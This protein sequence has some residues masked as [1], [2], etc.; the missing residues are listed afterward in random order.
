MI[1]KIIEQLAT[2]PVPLRYCY[3]WFVLRA[4]NLA[5]SGS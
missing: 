2:I 4:P 5:R 1:Q 3:G